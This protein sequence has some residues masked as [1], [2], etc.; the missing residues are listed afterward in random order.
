MAKEIGVHPDTITRHPDDYFPVTKLGDK[1]FVGRAA[2]AAWLAKHVPGAVGEAKPEVPQVSTSAASGSS[3]THAEEHMT[4]HPSERE[5]QGAIDPASLEGYACGYDDPEV[6]LRAAGL[7]LGSTIPLD[8]EHASAIAELAGAIGELGPTTTPGAPC[9]AGS[10]PTRKP[11]KRVE[12]T[13][14]GLSTI[15]TN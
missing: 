10:L 8:P 11:E 3:R 9:S 1:R 14:N 4:C 6:L 13:F 12:S 7:V 5:T 15:Q 2:Y